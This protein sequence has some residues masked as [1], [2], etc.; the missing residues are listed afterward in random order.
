MKKVNQEKNEKKNKFQNQLN[1]NYIEFKNIQQ[2]KE[3]DKIVKK[4]RNIDNIK[5]KKKEE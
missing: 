3:K 2:I 5:R 1:R 4:R